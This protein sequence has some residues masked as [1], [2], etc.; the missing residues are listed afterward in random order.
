M[1]NTVGL[2]GWDLLYNQKNL[3]YFY[4]TLKKA[5]KKQELSQPCCVQAQS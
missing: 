5:I 3:N 4:Y 2:H 1:T